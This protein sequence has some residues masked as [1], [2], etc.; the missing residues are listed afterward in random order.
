M[1]LGA[2]GNFYG[3]T[4]SGGTLG[5]GTVFELMTNGTLMNLVNFNGTNGAFPY[6]GLIAGP[7]N[8]LYG[9]TVG[10]GSVPN[11]TVFKLALPPYPIALAKNGTNCTVSTTT[12]PDLTN[13]IWSTTNLALPSAWQMLGT[14][15]TDDNGNG[16]LLDTNTAGIPVKFYR[17]SNP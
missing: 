16:S 4:Y 17:L 12:Y 1:L 8:R 15:T 7:G 6:G 13:T 10:S 11:G 9:T 3:T 2:D 14:L 5:F